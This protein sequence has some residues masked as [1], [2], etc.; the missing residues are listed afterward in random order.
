MAKTWKTKINVPYLR[1]M[2]EK[3]GRTLKEISVSTGHEASFVSKMLLDG[4]ASLP[5]L[6]L[7]CLLIGADENKALDVEEPKTQPQI[8]EHKPDAAPQIRQ[9]LDEI[10]KTLSELSKIVVDMAV[11]SRE[12]D[13]ET[14]KFYTSCKVVNKYKYGHI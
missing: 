12:L 4:R 3:S 2:I 9:D 7:L 5:S 6:R 8:E 10:K 11:H 13:E 1:K 14:K